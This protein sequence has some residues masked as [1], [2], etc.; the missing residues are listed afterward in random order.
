M[1]SKTQCSILII[2][3]NTSDLCVFL[4]TSSILVNYSL[5]K[6]TFFT[7]ES[8]LKEKDNDNDGVTCL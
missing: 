8:E 7:N 1:N 2:I 4:K 3:N 6:S 5:C